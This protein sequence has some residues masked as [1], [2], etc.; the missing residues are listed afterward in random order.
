MT[1]WSNLHEP[2]ADR[3]MIGPHGRAVAADSANRIPQEDAKAYAKLSV[4]RAA[5]IVTDAQ[6]NMD[7]DQEKPCAESGEE[8]FTVEWHEADDAVLY[9]IVAFSRPQQ[10]LTRLGYPFARRMQKRFARD[11]A[12]A[13]RR[14]VVEAQSKNR[15]QA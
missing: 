10:F 6:I 13:V 2:A 5:A 14:A 15:S 11:S 3:R 4:E 8:R 7:V 1:D 12:A 9:D